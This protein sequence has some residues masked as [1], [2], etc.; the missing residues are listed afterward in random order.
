MASGRINSLSSFAK[1]SSFPFS[2]SS[3]HVY[4]KKELSDNF[5]LSAKYYLRTSAMLGF[6]EL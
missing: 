3:V 5:I 2:E 1:F 6:G 4:L